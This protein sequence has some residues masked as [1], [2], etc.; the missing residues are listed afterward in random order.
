MKTNHSIIILFLLFALTTHAFSQPDEIVITEGSRIEI[1]GRTVAIEGFWIDNY[2][3]KADISVYYQE[4]SKPVTGGYKSGETI[5]VTEGCKHIIKSI[6]KF[7]LSSKG[8]VTLWKDIEYDHSVYRGEFMMKHSKNY[9]F[10]DEVWV[11]KKVFKDS[12]EIEINKN[13]IFIKTFLLK[14]DDIVWTGKYANS[15]SRFIESDDEGA[16]AGTIVFKRIKDLSYINRVG[17]PDEILNPPVH[18]PSGNTELII[19]KMKYYPKKRI[20][21]EELKNTPMK[22]W[23]L[24]IFYYPRGIAS[25]VIDVERNGEKLIVEFE[26]YKSFDTEEEVME[27][28]RVNRITDIILEV[29]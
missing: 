1:C 13:D 20:D 27:F 16:N 17:V 7:G 22:F 9:Y 10:G 18:L 4:N 12:A 24:K 11:V 29:E 25:M 8:K 2:E 23:V 5:T 21:E 14:H 6:L 15:I 19:R 3:L 26:G 28:A